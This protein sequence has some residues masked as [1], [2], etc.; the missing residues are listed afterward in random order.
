VFAEAA[1][2]YLW[3]GPAADNSDLV[4]DQVHRIGSE[5]CRIGTD[6]VVTRSNEEIPSLQWWFLDSIRRLF[7]AWA[8]IDEKALND[9]WVR[10]R[11]MREHFFPT[12]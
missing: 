5:A 3:V 1:S 8:I 2:V 12:S 7:P 4:M 11:W 10:R 9:L 6:L